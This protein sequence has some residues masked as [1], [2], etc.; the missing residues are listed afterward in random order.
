[1]QTLAPSSANIHDPREYK[2]CTL[3]IV[4]LVFIRKSQ[5]YFSSLFKAA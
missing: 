5:L 3:R 4:V 2:L 1:M